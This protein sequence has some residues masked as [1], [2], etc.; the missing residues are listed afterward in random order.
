ME[1]TDH[2]MGRRK[3]YPTVK[4]QVWGEE[5]VFGPGLVTLLEYM[6]S[7][8]SMKGACAEMGMSYSKGWKIMNRAE[9]ELGY[10]LVDRHHGGS[11]GGDCALTR[12][13]KSLAERYR[14][15]AADVQE[16]TKNVF[17]TYFPEYVQKES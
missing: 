12:E 6:E 4:V 15:M 14:K 7:C 1:R 11:H 2:K 17:G 8:G 13:G 5:Q 9:Q 10:P 3:L 16:Y